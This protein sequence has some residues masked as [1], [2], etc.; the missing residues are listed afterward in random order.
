MNDFN[1]IYLLIASFVLGL[2]HGIEW[3]HLAAIIDITASDVGLS[4]AGTGIVTRSYHISRAFWLST[5]Y[6]LGH[7]LVVIALG[8]A[9]RSFTT[10]FPL[11]FDSACERLVGISLILLPFGFL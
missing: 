8:L 11:W 4:L 5:C 3:D 10:L 6:G 2:R 9:A 7:S 1:Q